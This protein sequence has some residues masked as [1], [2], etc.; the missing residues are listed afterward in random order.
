MIGGI[1][2]GQYRIESHLGAGG[3]GDV[4]R[5]VQEKTG[6]LVAVKVLR[7]RSG[8]GAPSMERQVARFRREMRVCAELHH[9]HIVRLIDSGETEAS[10]LFSVFEYVPGVTLAELVHEKGALQVRTALDLMGQVLDALVCAHG[11][12]V[13]HRDLKPS[14]IMVSTTGSRPQITVLDFGI[15][16]FLEGMLMDEFADLTMTRE[17]LGTPSY[18]APEQLRGEPPSTKSDLYAWGLVLA[19]CIVGR[20][21]FAGPS[22]VEIAHRQLAAGPVPLPQRLQAH[23]LGVL[24]R[25]ALEKDPSRR[26][27]DAAQLMERLLEKRPLGDLIDANGYFISGEAETS[28]LQLNPPEGPATGLDAGA[29]PAGERRQITAV[30]CA[31]DVGEEAARRLPPEALDQ[32]LRDGHALCLGVAARFGGHPAGTLGGQVLFYFGFPRASDTD[33]RRSGI[34]AL[35]IAQE[36]RRRN[37]TAP[38]I[39]LEVRIGVHT[40]M[41]TVMGVEARPTSPIFGVTPSQAV[42]LAL[43]APP[44]GILISAASFR[45]LASSFELHPMSGPRGQPIHRLVAESRAESAAVFS[46][47]AGR[48]PLVG[49]RHELAA[50]E[51]AW[52]RARAE[53][54]AAV[55]VKGEP[56]I[57]KSRLVRELRRSL[58][59]AGA[60]WLEA[61]CLPEMSHSA[62]RPVIDLLAQEL[63]LIGAAGEDGARR[64]EA[65]LEPL[66]VDL[67][68]AMPLLGPWFNLPLC[69]P[70]K[71]LPFSP[72]KHKSLLLELLADL[73]LAIAGSQMAPILVEDLHW[74]DPT[75]LELL[76]LMIRKVGSTRCLVLLTARPDLR[77]DWPEGLVEVLPLK[78]LEGT[79]VA[80]IVQALMGAD[81]PPPHVLEDVI[82]RADGIPLFIEEI[83]RFVEDSATQAA[84]APAGE[85]VERQ[86]PARLRDLLTGRLDRLGRAKETA[87]LAAAVGREFD[88]RL[89]ASIFPGD[90]SVLLADLDQM[91]SS[92]LLIRRR[93]V[94][95]P[96]FMF[97]HALIR[98]AA[99][100]SLLDASRVAI[101]ARVAATLEGQ[102]P[103]VAANRP[104]LLAHHWASGGEKEKA[105]GYAKTATGMALAGCL[106]HEAAAHAS[107]AIG[108][109]GDIADPSRRAEVELELIGMLTPALMGTSGW[110]SEQVR[111]NIDRAEVLSQRVS[112]H[113]STQYAMLWL[114]LM[115]HHIRANWARFDEVRV[116]ALAVA[117][118]TNNPVL[119]CVVRSIWAQ[120]LVLR[121]RLVE[122]RQQCTL[123]LGLYDDQAHAMHRRYFGQDVEVFTLGALGMLLSLLGYCDQAQQAGLRAVQRAEEL[124]SPFNICLAKAF[125]AGAWHYQ[126]NREKTAEWSAALLRDADLFGIA[127]W[128]PIGKILGGWASGETAEAIVQIDLIAAIGNRYAGPYWSFTVAQTEAAAGQWPAALARSDAAIAQSDELGVLF[129]LPELHRLRAECLAALAGAATSPA[130]ASWAAARDAFERSIEIAQEQGAKLPELRATLGLFHLLVRQ[131]APDIARRRL[132]GVY[133][134]F[135]EGLAGPELTEARRL[136][137]GTQEPLDP[138]AQQAQ[139]LKAGA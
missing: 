67:G 116:R 117:A 128:P 21:V 18:A 38:A 109:V 70:W 49:R 16:A 46:G 58:E 139:Q 54:G 8:K 120:A 15:S 29:L 118:E 10:L 104:E 127:D 137:E 77:A 103:E 60:R 1:L 78:S 107:Q 85:A 111:A 80:E 48:V 13:I 40:G 86:V 89:L 5:A 42:Q 125:L 115:Y 122:A 7:P 126:G 121:G 11:R 23:W 69:E 63:N 91:V 75:T 57:G 17:I 138:Q 47:A 102:F 96:L 55:L 30:C 74:A 33:A 100:E 28:R 113:A 129:Y 82:R 61:R 14:N 106:Y 114:L 45:Y 71:P 51:R 20:P 99:Y 84:G 105:I 79:D 123:A 94:D 43:A 135:T 9:P 3:F 88:Y 66:G 73:V 134:W 31:I 83:V 39:P 131:G 64:L 68:S 37:E 4:F 124:K 87:Q 65:S 34:V 25:W 44:D 12:G 26:A 22:P 93:R 97:R 130:G 101:H 56:G 2:G 133:A 95:N 19:E 112:A 62:L 76:D 50:L 59:H 110:G 136:L 92:D 6:Q 41:V 32:A 35:E 132:S 36:V 90:E 53:R 52:A 27:G 24:L 119:E 72:Q 98:D 81:R 108:W